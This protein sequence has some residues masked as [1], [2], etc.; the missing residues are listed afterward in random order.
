VF[1]I[2]AYFINRDFGVNTV[3]PIFNA[4][5]PW[6]GVVFVIFF[7]WYATHEKIGEWLGQFKKSATKLHQS[8]NVEGAPQEESSYSF[9]KSKKFWIS[10]V[11]IYL[12][13][14]AYDMGKSEDRILTPE[15]IRENINLCGKWGGQVIYD[16]RGQY[17]DCAIN[18]RLE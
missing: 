9:L 10:L 15:E 18:G 5:F 6:V 17:Q 4:V 11:V 14:L 1:T 2:Y 13:W 16:G 8:V 7:L 12:I 3:T